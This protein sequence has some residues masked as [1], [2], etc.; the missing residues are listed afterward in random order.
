MEPDRFARRFSFCQRRRKDLNLTI[1]VAI[2]IGKLCFI[3]GVL[4]PMRRMGTHSGLRCRPLFFC[5]VQEIIMDATHPACVPP[6]SSLTC[7]A[8]ERAKNHNL[9]S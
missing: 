9:Y 8:W 5:I 3:S 6:K 7:A 4:V 1:P 2:H